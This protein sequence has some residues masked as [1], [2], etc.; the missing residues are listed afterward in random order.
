[1]METQLV[2]AWRGFLYISNLLQFVPK[3][4]LAAESGIHAHLYDALIDEGQKP[5]DTITIDPKWKDIIDSLFD[6][7]LIDLARKSGSVI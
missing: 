2:P 4:L 1:M 6:Q 7:A 5:S 3:S